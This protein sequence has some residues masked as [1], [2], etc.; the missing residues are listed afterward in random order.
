MMFLTFFNKRLKKISSLI[1]LPNKFFFIRSYPGGFT[2]K[3]LTTVAKI[4][5][6]MPKAHLAPCFLRPYLTQY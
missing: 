5:A 3:N 1:T 2:V 6:V 4:G